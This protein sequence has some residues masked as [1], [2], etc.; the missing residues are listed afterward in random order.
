MAVKKARIA[1]VTAAALMPALWLLADPAVPGGPPAPILLY[2]S[3]P[4][5]QTLDQGEGGGN[6]FAS[7]LIELLSHPDLSLAAFPSELRRLTVRKSDGFQT[8][9]VPSRAEPARW[10]IRPKPAD[11]TRMAMVIV[12]SD[13]SASG[14]ATSLPGAKHDASRIAAALTGAGF[15]TEGIVDP[16]R[17]ELPDMLRRFAERSA[18]AEFAIMY[19][20]GHG[21]EVNGTVHL[22]PGD[23]PVSERNGALA[24]KAVPL[25]QFA[26]STR[27]RHANLVFYGGCRDDPLGP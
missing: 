13:Y 26:R 18:A 5:Q 6:P 27:A 14:G 22:L 4:G 25:S 7:A 10:K 12:F 15:Q 23:Y 21:V 20:T 19:V 9:D 3:Q 17:I 16:N 8:P 2:A 24:Q 11:E 1:A